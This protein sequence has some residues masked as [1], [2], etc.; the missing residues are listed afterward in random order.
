MAFQSRWWGLLTF[1][2]LLEG[3]WRFHEV[4]RGI[5]PHV[6]N[7][8]PWAGGEEGDREWDSEEPEG[9]R[10][11]SSVKLYHP[12]EM[13]LLVPLTSCSIC[14]FSLVVLLVFCIG[15]SQGRSRQSGWGSFSSPK[16]LPPS[17]KGGGDRSCRKPSGSLAEVLPWVEESFEREN[18]HFYSI[19][20]TF[21]CRFSG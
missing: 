4:G 13:G 12:T 21:W 15:A 9:A 8:G 6:W 17:R 5:K 11:W 19:L 16:R 10:P 20:L 1:K 18:I 7:P 14:C 2:A 3:R